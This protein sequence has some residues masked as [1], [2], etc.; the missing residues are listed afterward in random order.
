MVEPHSSN[1]RVITTNILGVRIFWMSEY[2]GN[3]R[4]FT[5][6]TYFPELLQ[7]VENEKQKWT[8]ELEL[9]YEQ[10]KESWKV[11]ELETEKL[12]WTLDW[13]EKMKRE[14]ENWIKN[15][16]EPAKQKWKLESDERLR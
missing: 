11:I 5:I 4:Y 2:L 1:F 14:K 13:E 10:E 3:L 8:Q 12:N 16:L 6:I 15:E 9:K 7:E